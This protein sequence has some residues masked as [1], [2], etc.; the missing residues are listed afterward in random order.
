LPQAVL[1]TA[2][3]TAGE[4]V[5]LF[6]FNLKGKNAEEVAALLDRDGVAVRAGLHCAPAAHRHMGTLPHGTVR[7]SPSRYATAEEW[8][9]VLQI[10]YKL[11]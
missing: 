7:L 1:Y 10:I 9:K 3:P 2:R 5:P 8:H 6:S 11:S 4:S